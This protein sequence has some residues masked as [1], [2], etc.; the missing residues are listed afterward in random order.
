MLE[1]SIPT[2]YRNLPTPTKNRIPPR[3]TKTNTYQVAEPNNTYQKPKPTNTYQNQYLSNIE[4]TSTY[5]SRN[6]P[7]RTKSRKQSLQPTRRVPW[8][9]KTP[10]EPERRRGGGGGWGNYQQKGVLGLGKTPRRTERT[11]QS[12]IPKSVTLQSLSFSF[13][14]CLL[15]SYSTIVIVF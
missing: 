9:I 7:I 3:P 8:A 1:Q 5:K 10:K 13:C 4:P 2:K 11:K 15:C 14:L 6:I 12:S